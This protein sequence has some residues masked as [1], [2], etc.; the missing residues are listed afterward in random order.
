MGK[1]FGKKCFL[2]LSMPIER[3]DNCVA[4]IGRDAFSV[5]S[6]WAHLFLI[7]KKHL[8]V[9]EKHGVNKLCSGFHNLLIYKIPLSV[10]NGAVTYV[11]QFNIQ[12]KGDK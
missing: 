9:K 5:R 10:Y 3:I 4:T 1:Y 8:S 7:L 11:L 2:L 12:A 6:D